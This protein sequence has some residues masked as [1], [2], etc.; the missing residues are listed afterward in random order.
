LRRA[1]RRGLLISGRLRRSFAVAGEDQEKA[2]DKKTRDSKKRVEYAVK[3]QTPGLNVHSGE[4][5]GAQAFRDFVGDNEI[6]TLNVAGPRASDEPGGGEFVKK[7]LDNA[8]PA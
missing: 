1:K 5:D 4:E 2:A 6:N 8:C 7:V 3:Y